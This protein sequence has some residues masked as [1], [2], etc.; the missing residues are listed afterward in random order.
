MRRRVDARW[1]SSPN[2]GWQKASVSDRLPVSG[3]LQP[4]GRARV[5]LIRA[6]RPAKSGPCGSAGQTLGTLL[7]RSFHNLRNVLLTHA[8]RRKNDAEIKRLAGLYSADDLR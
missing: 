6:G 2:R 7:Y 3:R 1:F 4:T 8:D 5:A